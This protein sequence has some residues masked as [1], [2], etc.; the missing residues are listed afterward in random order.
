MESARV[1]TKC[2]VIRF[3]EQLSLP[4]LAAA[5]LH[6][7]LTLHKNICMYMSSYINIYIYIYIY[8]YN[9]TN[10]I[11]VHLMSMK[12][13]QILMLRPDERLA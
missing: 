1:T 10:L 3:L 11:F 8:I 6:S 4:Q 13:E 7:T 5:S 9:I 12:R 2:Q